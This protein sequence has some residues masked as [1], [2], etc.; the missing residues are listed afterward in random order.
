MEPLRLGLFVLAVA[1]GERTQSFGM[2]VAL[3]GEL[4]SQTGDVDLRVVLLRDLAKRIGKRELG[5]VQQAEIMRELH[6]APAGWDAVLRGAGAGPSPRRTS[7]RCTAPSL[8]T[9]CLDTGSQR[10]GVSS[11]AARAWPP[12]PAPS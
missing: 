11:L 3:R 5:L 2:R 7:S 8:K 10:L 9:G 6:Q 4:G 12:G 1:F